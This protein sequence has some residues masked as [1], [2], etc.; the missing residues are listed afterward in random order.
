MKSCKSVTG[1]PKAIGRVQVHSTASRTPCDSVR[2]PKAGSTATPRSRQHPS[3][4]GQF[5]VDTM[6]AN[7]G[8]VAVLWCSWPG[9]IN[10]GI[11][12]HDWLPAFWATWVALLVPIVFSHVRKSD[13]PTDRV[14]ERHNDRHYLSIR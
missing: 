6:S 12:G 5:A 3:T 14:G 2:E 4:F 13:D 11:L 10:R 1:F 7:V 8:Y 9:T